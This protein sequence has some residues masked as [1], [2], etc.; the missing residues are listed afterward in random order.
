M[1]QNFISKKNNTNDNDEID[2][3]Q[4]L[5]FLIRNKIL[6]ASFSFIFFILSTVFSSV[7]KKTWEG[8]FQI[9]LENKDS[10][11]PTSLFP[12]SIQRIVG[13]GKSNLSN[14]LKTE[15]GILESPSVLLPAFEFANSS[16]NIN[17]KNK[18]ILKF[19]SWKKRNLTIELQEDTSILNISY[20]DKRK[21]III[22]VLN[23][24]SGIYQDYSGKRKKK[25]QENGLSYLRDQILIYNEKSSES[26][27]KAQGFAIDEDFSFIGLTSFYEIPKQTLEM[28]KRDKFNANSLISPNIAIENQRAIAANKIREIDFQ[29]EQIEKIS[30]DPNQFQ[31]IGS[32]IP[33]L[34]N[35]GLPEMLNE[36]DEELI[37]KRQYYTDESDLIKNLLKKRIALIELIKEKSIG[38]LKAEKMKTLAQMKAAKRPKDVLLKYKELIREAQRNEITLINLEN[39]LIGLE[40]ESSKKQDPWELITKPTLKNS[41]ISPNSLLINILGVIIGIFLG[42]FYSIFKEKKTNLI[43]NENIINSL[44]GIEILDKIYF[45]T[46]KFEINSRDILVDEILDPQDN[47]NLKFVYIDEYPKINIEK[48]INKIFDNRLNFIVVENLKKLNNEDKIILVLISG[49][50]KINDLSKFIKRLSSINKKLL[51]AVIIKNYE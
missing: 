22:P 50:S 40:L 37:E 45:D 34:L 20:R 24:I 19:S 13:L 23:K 39:Q 25:M 47:A 1:D 10:L 31:Y 8:E 35:E 28:N 33:A 4:I 38:Y 7:I 17:S 27:K 21:E 3:N 18:N 30:E 9:V 12:T 2:F 32:T 16:I 26:L 15:V 36:F 14:S 48:M 44:F 42:I 51:G 43:Y 41:P 49:K 46:N 11:A 6:I 29:L 5:N